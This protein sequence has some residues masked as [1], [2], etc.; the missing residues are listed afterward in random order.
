VIAVIDVGILA[1]IGMSAV[2]YM[3]EQQQVSQ[4]Q[5]Q[6]EAQSAEAQSTTTS[7]NTPWQEFGVFIGPFQKHTGVFHNENGVFIPWT[8]MCAA[9]QSYLV[10]SCGSLLN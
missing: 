1:I 4:Q 8:T 10:E 7:G 9:E 2:R 6:Q 3:Q 5:I